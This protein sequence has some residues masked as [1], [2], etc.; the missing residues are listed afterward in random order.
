MP[1]AFN[2]SQDQT[3][4]FNSRLLVLAS[5]LVLLYFR[6]QFSAKRPHSLS[7][8]FLMNLRPFRRDAYS[9]HPLSLSITFCVFCARPGCPLAIP[10]NFCYS[11]QFNDG[12]SIG[13]LATIDCEPRQARKGAA[14]TID[15]GA[16]VW[17]L[18]LPPNL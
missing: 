8:L 10:N 5:S 16:E 17:L 13:P 14:V 6:T 1:P 4:Q 9:T 7:S 11:S 15:S 3:L 18:E 2:L 12:G